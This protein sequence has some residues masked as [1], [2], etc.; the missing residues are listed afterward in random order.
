MKLGD[1]TVPFAE[2]FTALS[3]GD[4][5]LILDSGVWFSLDVPELDRLRQLIAEARDLADADEPG[6]LRL[7]VEHAGLWDELVGLGIVAEQA[8]SWRKAVDGLLNLDAIPA[9]CL[10]Y[11]SRCV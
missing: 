9:V 6:S 10:L 4:D 7:R 2:L 11:T 3:R 5:H 1:E 8:A